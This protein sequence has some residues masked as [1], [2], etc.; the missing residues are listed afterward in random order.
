MDR[1]G[2][3]SAGPDKDRKRPG[4]SLVLK[5]PACT[6]RTWPRPPVLSEAVRT[7]RKRLSETVSGIR[8]ALCGRACSTLD[9]GR[10]KREMERKRRTLRPGK[11]SGCLDSAALEPRAPG[12][13]LH[14]STC[15]PGLRATNSPP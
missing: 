1:H 14:W 8:H 12:G 6:H 15:E 9:D 13:G 3:G 2:A 7:L 11:A 10:Q 5:N 4:F